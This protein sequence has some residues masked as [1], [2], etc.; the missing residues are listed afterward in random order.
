MTVHHKL[1]VVLTFIVRDRTR[2]EEIRRLAYDIINTQANQ[3]GMMLGWLDQWGLSPVAADREPMAWMAGSGAHD[4]HTASTGDARMPGMATPAQL[5]K[6]GELNG[7]AAEIEYLRLMTAH[8]KGGVDMAEAC[9]DLCSP[10]AQRQLADGMVT[11]QQSELELMADLLKERGTA[12]R[13]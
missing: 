5:E 8:H 7:E 1:G 2:N 3:R 9:V 11:G 6:L 13:P 10:G 12:P 4:G